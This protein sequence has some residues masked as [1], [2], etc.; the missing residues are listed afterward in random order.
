ML[1]AE[2]LCLKPGTLIR[3]FDVGTSTPLNGLHASPS[4]VGWNFE[5][6]EHTF[7]K[8][9]FRVYDDRTLSKWPFRFINTREQDPIEFCKHFHDHWHH[10]TKNHI[11]FWGN[12]GD[13]MG[14]DFEIQTITS[15]DSLGM[16]L[17][18]F[19]I[20]EASIGANRVGELTTVLVKVLF[21]DTIGWISL[22]T[23]C[24]QVD[25]LEIE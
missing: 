6:P 4:V 3:G 15:A 11:Q 20:M 13:G 9:T 25:R 7:P 10:F 23:E 21:E 2:L 5:N 19:C 17:G 24:W 16:V 8:L 12:Y 18:D 1:L 14:H 22:I